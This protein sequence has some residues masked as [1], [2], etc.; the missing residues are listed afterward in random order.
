M[1]AFAGFGAILLLSPMQLTFSRL[2]AGYRRYTVARTDT[3]VKTINEILVG[4]D[5]L[6]MMGWEESLEAKVGEVRREEFNSISSAAKLKS[7]NQSMFFASLSIVSL[8]TFFTMHFRGVPFTPS[9]VFTAI[10]LFNII[11]MPLTNF[12][13]FAV[14][15]LTEARVAFGR[16]TR[17]LELGEEVANDQARFEKQAAE[18]RAENARVEAESLEAGD[19]P[20]TIRME[21][22]SFAWELT[23]EM[24]PS[25]VAPP[26]AGDVPSPS[27]APVAPADGAAH[28]PVPSPSASVSSTGFSAQHNDNRQ[29]LRLLDM[30]IRPGT[31]VGVV[32]SIGSYK[33]SLLAALLGEMT[34]M[35]GGAVVRG[36]VAY[37]SQQSWIFAAT[38]RENILFGRPFDARRYARTIRA[39]Q[40]VED[41]K[42]Q[43][44][45]DQTQIGEKGVNLSGGQRARLSCA[46]A[47]YGLCDIYLLDDPLAALDGVVATKLFDAVLSDRGGLLSGTTRV[48][49]THQTHLLVD[50]HIVYLEHGRIKAQGSFDDLV[51][52]GLL[53]E[54]QR[55]A[56]ADNDSVA[57]GMQKRK[58]KKEMRERR[59]IRKEAAANGKADTAASEPEAAAGGASTN[60]V[61][62]ESSSVGSLS[63]SV[64]T[65]MFKV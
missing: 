34:Q 45:G 58:K 7:I 44:Q 6:K 43:P 27:G 48:L 24:D 5:V 33:S 38:I 61:L 49:V 37:A 20:G 42:M 4:A 26:A 64:F 50:A 53:T 9:N 14:E 63:L 31:L 51:K 65:K 60:I 36:S 23:E 59:R 3:R 19:K 29:G 35:H 11:K 18:V 40:L 8:V 62:A 56:Q 32:G 12:I 54:S 57:E 39:C 16:I 22:A 17:F 10:A 2:F 25:V 46:R 47:V 30:H 41:I 21:R 52:L 28:A 55:H 15:K 1:A 13:P